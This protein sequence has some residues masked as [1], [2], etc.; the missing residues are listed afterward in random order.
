[1]ANLN[2][3]RFFRRVFY[4]IRQFL[5]AVTSSITDDNMAFARN[6]LT[7]PEMALF[8]LLPH[9]EQKHSI[10]I[11]KK[12]LALAHGSALRHDKRVLAKAGLL[13]DVGKSAVRLGIMD[14]SLLVII[15][16]A[17][18][19]VYN[20]LAEKGRAEN[21]GLVYRKFYVHREHGKIGA[22][23]LRKAG[24]EE[25]VVSIVEGHDAPPKN[26]DPV[27]LKFLRKIDSEN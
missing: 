25:R 7:I 13:H 3:P 10:V 12:M 19:P 8:E 20:G 1:L 18:R 9:D 11:A 22:E 5:L 26:D 23:V 15:R 24:T 4:R 6:H 27:E 2:L 14:R 17:L 16:R 21:T